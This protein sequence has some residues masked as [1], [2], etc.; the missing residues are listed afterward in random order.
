MRKG[1]GREVYADEVCARIV[2]VLVRL[3]TRRIERRLRQIAEVSESIEQA[4]VLCGLPIQTAERYC[5]PE[6][7]VK[8]AREILEWR[9][10]LHRYE[11]IL[12]RALDIREEEQLVF[13][14]VAAQAPSELISLVRRRQRGRV[15]DVGPEPGIADQVEHFAVILITARAS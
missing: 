14:N 4:Q 12:L 10:I 3:Q 2:L 15:R 9:G 5:L 6:R 8:S 1:A 11:N 13:Q 7:R